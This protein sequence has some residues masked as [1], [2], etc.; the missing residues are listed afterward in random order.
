MTKL[1]P[2]LQ[3]DGN[4]RE[5]MEFYHSVLG[6][7]LTM[8][9]HGEA[10][11]DTPEDMRDKIIHSM[12]ETDSFGLMASDIHPM[13]CPPHVAGNNVQ[14]CL[15]GTD[16]EK[17]EGM[18]SKLAEGGEVTMPLEKQFWGDVFGSLTDRFGI[19]WMINIAEAD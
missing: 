5:V 10:F 7:E 19:H 3:L 13:Y 11:P 18:F 6:G 4:C 9:T 1:R 8:Q 17:L 2:Y 15:V 16:R 12:I 14:L